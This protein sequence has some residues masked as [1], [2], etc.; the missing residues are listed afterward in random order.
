MT[1]KKNRKKMIILNY[2]YPNPEHN[3]ALDDALLEWVNETQ[4]S[5]IL[6][7]W[8]PLSPF[9]VL[10]RSRRIKAEVSID[11]CLKDNVPILRRQSGGGTILQTSGCLNFC[12]VFPITTHPDLAF[13]K[14]TATFV[15]KKHI[16][17]L[18]NILPK[19]TIKGTSD[20]TIDNKKIAGH[21]QRRLKNA[22]LFHGS[23]LLDVNLEQISTYLAHPI[24]EPDYRSKRTHADFLTNCDIST[25]ALINAFKHGWN[26]TQTWKSPND[27]CTRLTEKIV[28]EKYRNESW[29][30]Q[31]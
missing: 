8:E 5:P 23:F 24:D 29:N 12:L 28:N 15:L 13:I 6:R 22:V 14:S 26:P 16:K 9:V 1:L 19:L 7:L 27:F 4:L 2:T 20:L 18:Q 17:M 30:Y 25:D 31:H 3:L 10:G 11:S 21:A